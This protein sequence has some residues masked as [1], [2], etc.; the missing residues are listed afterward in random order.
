MNQDGSLPAGVK[1]VPF[2]DRSSLIGVTT[3]T[4]LHNLLF[5]CVLI[6]FIQW[7][8]LGDLRSAIIVGVEYSLRAVFRHH[9]AGDAGR[10][11]QPAFR[12]RGGPRNHCG[13]RGDSRGKH[14][15]EF[16]KIARRKT[17]AVP[18]SGRWFLGPGPDKQLASDS[19]GGVD[20]PFA[21]DFDQRVCRWTK[22]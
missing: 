7:I 2:Y 9:P 1:V 22:R 4:V 19:G 15:P 17:N 13:F 5:G 3:H 21:V 10:K 20:R 12:R 16:A 14:L 6:F 18:P 8:F 11:R